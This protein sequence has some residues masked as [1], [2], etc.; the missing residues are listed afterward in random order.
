MPESQDLNSKHLLVQEGIVS[1][2]LPNTTF[3][4]MLENKSEILAHLSG[5]M[6]MNYIKVLPGD[7][8]TVE[9]SAYNLAQGRITRRN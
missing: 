2:V 3:R 8:V 6:R 9:L 1:E 7:K 4:V 5:K